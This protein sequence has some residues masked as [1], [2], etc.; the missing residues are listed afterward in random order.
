MSPVILFVL[1]LLVIFAVISYFLRPTRTETAIQ[2]HLAS[3]EEVRTARP[4]ATI[5]KEKRLSSVPLLH[6]LLNSVPGSWALSRL[7]TQA[8]KNWWVSSVILYSL[9]A[10]AAA[11]WLASFWI[12]NVLVSS[13][14][15]VIVGL[16]PY[17]YLYFLRVK[18]F[19]DCDTLL[20]EA[21]DLMARALRAG[22]ALSSVLQMVGEEI[23]DPLGAEMRTVYEEQSLGLPL[24]ESLLRLVERVPSDDMRFLATAM[25][26]QKETGGNLAHILDKTGFVMRERIRLRGQVKIY[27]A[28]GRVTGWVISAL[29]FILFGLISLFNPGYT[30]ILYTDPL[31]VRLI[32]VGIIMMVIGAFVIRKIINVKV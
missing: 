1:L 9:L 10:A 24:R 6:D 27:T 19:E 28:Q 32:Y 13:G 17:A 18:R 7:I 14:I 31:G 23:R 12:S 29:P 26:L 5:L 20:P 3:I 2:R 30:K 16:S 11:W 25:L 8:G 4:D 15:G 21:V 22:H